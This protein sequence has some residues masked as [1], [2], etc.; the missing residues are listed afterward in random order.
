MQTLT[1]KTEISTHT[2]V[3]C[4]TFYQ[5]LHSLAAEYLF[6]LCIP[7]KSRPDPSASSNQL[8]VLRI[9]LLITEPVISAFASRPF[10]TTSGNL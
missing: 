3:S 7:V 8:V 6:E 5:Y 10:G 4:G 9:K 1:S 2:Y